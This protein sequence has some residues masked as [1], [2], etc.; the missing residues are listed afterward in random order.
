MAPIEHVP[1]PAADVLLEQIQEF[2]DAMASQDPNDEQAVQSILFFFF[3]LFLGSV[4]LLRS[5]TFFYVL[6]F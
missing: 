3:L 1:K 6:F 5:S 4:V 2:M